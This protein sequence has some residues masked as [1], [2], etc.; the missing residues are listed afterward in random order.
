MQNGWLHLKELIKLRDFLL[1][2]SLFV[3]KLQTCESFVYPLFYNVCQP[4][5]KNN[6]KIQTLMS[7][8]SK[9]KIKND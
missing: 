5:Y 3:L 7:P 2:L 8:D 6:R 1:T 4:A 9:T